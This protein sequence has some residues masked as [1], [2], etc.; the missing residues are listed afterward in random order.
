MNQS[1]FPA[2]A[3]NSLKGREK[4]RPPGAIFFA[5]KKWREIFEPITKRSNGNLD[6]HLKTGRTW[7][8]EISAISLLNRLTELILQFKIKKLDGLSF[9]YYTF[10]DQ[11]I[12]EKRFKIFYT[13]WDAFVIVIVIV[14]VFCFC[15]TN[16]RFGSWNLSGTQKVAKIS[17]KN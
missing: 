12:D 17:N 2:S 3:C 13:D 5:F 11:W 4:S 8:I 14:V 9:C 1:E 6:S 15:H 10:R 16:V 7:V